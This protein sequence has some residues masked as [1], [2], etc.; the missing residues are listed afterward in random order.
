M[1]KRRGGKMSKWCAAGIVRSFAW[2]LVGAT[3]GVWVRLREPG[4][5]IEQVKRGKRHIG[6]LLGK[7]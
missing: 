4:E 2:G 5:P 7:I 6:R 1:P 3:V